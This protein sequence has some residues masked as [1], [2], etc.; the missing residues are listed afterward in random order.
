MRNHVLRKGYDIKL[1]GKA[2]G[3]VSGAAKSSLVAIQPHEFR[4][5]RPKLSIET[6]QAVKIGSELFVSKENPTM[7]FLSPASGLVKEIRRGEGRKLLEI[8]IESDDKEDYESFRKHSPD[9]IRNL[10]RRE[11]LDELLNGGLWPYFRERPFSRIA[12]PERKARDIFVSAFDSAPLAPDY[13]LLLEGNKEYFEFGMMLVSRLTD[14]KVYLAVKDGEDAANQFDLNHDNIE[15]HSFKGAHPSGNISVH[16]HHIAPI[17]AGE[18]LWYL[19]AQHVALLGK[20]FLEG[21]YPVERLV[22]VAG[23]SVKTEKRQYYK[24]RLGSEISSL[25]GPDDLVD[26]DVRY[27]CGN[28]LSGFEIKESGYMGFYSN[29]LTVIPESEERR[30]LGWMA[31]GIDQES[32]SWSFLSKLIPR[33]EYI[34]DTRLHGG[35]RAF[36]QTGDY[37]KVLPMDILPMHLVKSIMAEDVEEME[38]LGLLEC[39]EEDFALC[40]YICPSKIDFGYYIRQGLSLLESEG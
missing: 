29:L 9:E 30:F 21:K 16:I 5:I 27:I 31:P 13:Q 28:V 2:V 12:D 22:A 32:F 10:E 23:S 26:K 38:A 20:F 35:V 18:V 33:K 11:I 8:I 40:S 4:G 25:L 34:K 24:T 6:G 7:R 37:E 14:G 1:A 36:I 3:T 39:D 19:Y 17:N 15:I